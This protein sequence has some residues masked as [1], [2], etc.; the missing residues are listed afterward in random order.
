METNIQ[1]YEEDYRFPY[2]WTADELSPWAIQYLGYVGIVAD[3]VPAQAGL[4]ALDI[5][6]G[7][8]RLSAEL[9]ARGLHVTGLD[10]SQNAIHH[11]RI[12]VPNATFLC[13]DVLEIDRHRELHES[14]D[15]VIAVELIEHL[16]PAA[17]GKLMRMAHLALKPDGILIASV[18]SLNM[19][20]RNP[21]HYK[22][23]SEEE[24]VALAENGGL[25][26]LEEL[27]GNHRASFL[28]AVKLY[29]LLNNRYY[30]IRFARSFLRWFYRKYFMIA[31]PAQA[32]RYLLKA[33][34]KEGGPSD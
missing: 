3:M 9:A 21:Q 16:P 19:P 23:F 24:L 4:S 28:R 8:G 22:H 15:V 31:P 26:S 6:C 1:S 12:L 18:P 13:M 5:G 33:R 10:F 32:C 34:K 27:V 25:F 2:H 7:D 11:A 30:D 17:H 20:L 29:R 14:F